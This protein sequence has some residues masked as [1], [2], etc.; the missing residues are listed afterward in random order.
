MNVKLQI[1]KLRC[2]PKQAVPDM[3]N[4]GQKVPYWPLRG[5]SQGHHYVLRKS[6]SSCSKK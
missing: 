6:K 2:R 1:S 4:R 5:Q 3:N